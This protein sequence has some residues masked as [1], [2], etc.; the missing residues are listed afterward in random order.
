MQGLELQRWPSNT[1][2]LGHR[3]QRMAPHPCSGHLSSA[4]PLISYPDVSS[5]TAALSLESLVCFY[6]S[7]YCSRSMAHYLLRANL[8][9]L[10]WTFL[11]YVLRPSCSY[12]PHF[13]IIL[14]PL[15][16]IH[17]P[18][19]ISA[20]RYRLYSHF[21]NHNLPPIQS[22]AFHNDETHVKCFFSLQ[23]NISDP[24]CRKILI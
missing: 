18:P 21:H 9:A 20:H 8:P 23:L 24:L 10:T 1:C 4:S 12:I 7:V 14:W 11:H 3:K 2:Q 13:W 6:I 15:R 22:P 17:K 16:L 5:S 19:G